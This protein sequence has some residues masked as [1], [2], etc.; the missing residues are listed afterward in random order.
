MQNFEL[1]L[2]Y[3]GDFESAG[4]GTYVD[5][6]KR[7]HARGVCS[8][9]SGLQERY[10]MYVT[11]S[12]LCKRKKMTLVG[13]RVRMWMT[14]CFVHQLLPTSLKQKCAGAA[15][16][17]PAIRPAAARA[18]GSRSSSRARSGGRALRRASR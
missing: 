6:G 11:G 5:C 13:L 3:S 18:G 1:V 4:I 14:A 10:T 15:A 12:L 8:L 17:W 16:K 7:L 2:D 9:L